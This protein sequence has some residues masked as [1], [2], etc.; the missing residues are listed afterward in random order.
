MDEF[1]E[2]CV[3]NGELPCDILKQVVRADVC[4][5][6]KQDEDEDAEWLCLGCGSA[7]YVMREEFQLDGQSTTLRCSDCKRNWSYWYDDDDDE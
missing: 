1:T 6:S 2:L 3:S 7:E 4:E 5:S